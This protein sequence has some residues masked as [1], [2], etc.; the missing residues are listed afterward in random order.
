MIL[1]LTPSAL[2]VLEVDALDHRDDD[3]ED[4]YAVIRAAYRGDGTIVVNSENAGDI[5]NALT[6]LANACDEALTSRDYHIDA[7]EKKIQRAARSNFTTLA[8]KARRA[9]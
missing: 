6:C 3:P 5:A 7:D 8:L 2:T 1:R 9:A 4:D